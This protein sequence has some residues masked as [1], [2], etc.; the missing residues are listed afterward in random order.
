MK[1]PDVMLLVTSCYKDRS[2]LRRLVVYLARVPFFNSPLVSCHRTF[3]HRWIC[4]S[5]RLFSGFIVWLKE[6][7]LI[8]GSKEKSWNLVLTFCF[9]YFIRKM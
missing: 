3:Y 9:W 1:V 6:I 5:P 7:N 4:S 2:N 8:Q